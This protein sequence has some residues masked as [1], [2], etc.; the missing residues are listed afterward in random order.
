M[1]PGRPICEGTSPRAAGVTWFKSLH[2][3]VCPWA[4]DRQKVGPS[5]RI[6]GPIV[7]FIFVLGAIGFCWSGV[8][9]VMK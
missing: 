5:L 1:V 2:F 4:P 7:G 8:E 9:T 3:L 6:L